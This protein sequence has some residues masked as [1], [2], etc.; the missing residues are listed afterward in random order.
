MKK[1][2][3]TIGDLKR[4]VLVLS[5]AACL[6]LSGC[7][8][9]SETDAQQGV[10]TELTQQENGEWKVTDERYGLDGKKMAILHHLDGR[11]DPLQGEALERGLNQ[12]SQQVQQSSGF[13]GMGGLWAVLMF[14]RMGSMMGYA[15][16]PNP[17][18]YS[19][20]GVYERSNTM[21]RQTAPTSGRS[22]FFR[23][24]RGYSA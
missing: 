9:S 17:R 16:N 10:V 19:N 11:T 15:A 24:S 20:P 8:N 14:S 23:G 4:N 3:L 5:A 2:Y 13:G 21:Y 22:G 18:V 6:G 12:Q 1:R 7:G